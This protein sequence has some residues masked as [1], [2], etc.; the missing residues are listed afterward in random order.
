MSQA[1]SFCSISGSQFALPII[2]QID[3]DGVAAGCFPWPQEFEDVF[4]PINFLRAWLEGVVLVRVADEDERL[5]SKSEDIGGALPPQARFARWVLFVKRVCRRFPGGG[6]E[7]GWAGF[8]P[9]G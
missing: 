3:P 8:E 1:R 5:C 7:R 6:G 4:E 9:G 2:D